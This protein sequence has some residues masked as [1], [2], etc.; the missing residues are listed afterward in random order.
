MVS[1]P[2]AQGA[3]SPLSGLANRASIF[4]GSNQRNAPCRRRAFCR[5]GRT[6]QFLRVSQATEYRLHNAQSDFVPFHCS[7]ITFDRK[8][9]G[10]RGLFV[11]TEPHDALISGGRFGPRRTRC[12]RY[13]SSSV[14]RRPGLSSKYSSR[15]RVGRGCCRDAVLAGDYYRRTEFRRCFRNEQECNH[16]KTYN[17]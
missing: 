14:R 6:V 9:T 16:R 11:A 15:C 8:S 3:G 12:R 4:S 7:L 10:R 5:A 2:A 13:L 1:T 17:C